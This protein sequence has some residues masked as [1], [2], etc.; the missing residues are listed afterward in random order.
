[1]K[2]QLQKLVPLSWQKR[3]Y[4]FKHPETLDEVDIIFELLKGN[5]TDKVMLDVGAHIGN[6]LEPFARND[7]KVYAFEPD[8]SNRSKLMELVARFPNVRVHPIALSDTEKEAMAFYASEVSSGIS[9][10]LN[11]HE[12][13]VT[14]AQVR[15]STLKKICEE[16]AITKVSLLKTDTEGY[17]LPVLRGNDWSS[18][19]PRAIVCEFDDFKTRN[20]GYTLRDQADLLLQNGYKLV[21]SEW[22]PIEE[23]GKTHRWR[24]F[25]TDPGQVKG[26][27]VWGNIIAVKP[28]DWQALLKL[29]L[30]HGPVGT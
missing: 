18:V 7:W 16:N 28:K 29:L 13:H 6:A 24:R 19:H 14:T 3:W 15:V 10:L 25:T 1:M 17:D 8:P 9:S 30:K 11:F 21:V 27:R 23:Y 20:L 4:K 2:K 5:D 12:S 26:E 22:Y